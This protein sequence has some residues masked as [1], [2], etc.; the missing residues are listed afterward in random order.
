[1]QTAIDKLTERLNK[2]FNYFP[3]IKEL[4]RWEGFLKNIGL[5]DD[6]VRRLFNKEMVVGSGELYS[7]EH[8][9]RFKAENASPKLEQDKAKP[10]NIRF[11][12]NGTD[13]FDWFKQ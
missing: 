10:Q 4:L 6:M 9:K 11:T 13:I 2:I 7:K 5:P 1:M 8:S 3:H 12:I